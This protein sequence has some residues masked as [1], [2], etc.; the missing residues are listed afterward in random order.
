M[1]AVE[2]WKQ[3]LIG[4]RR[5]ITDLRLTATDVDWS[6]GTGPQAT[7]PLLFLIMAMSGRRQACHNLAGPGVTTLASR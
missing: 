5:R 2:T 3:M 7:G 6:T 4:A 1:N